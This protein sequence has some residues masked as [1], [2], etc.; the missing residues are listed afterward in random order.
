M[1]AAIVT[2]LIPKKLNKKWLTRMNTTEKIA[3]K[4]IDV[5]FMLAKKIIH[6]DSELAQRYVYVARK[7]AMRTRLNIPKEYK[8]LICKKCKKFILPGVNCRVRIQHKRQSHLVITCFNCN[9]YTRIS[10]LS[11]EK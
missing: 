11:R 3:L 6:D 7:I 1:V 5:L 9:K 10:L 2:Y 4:R 8:S